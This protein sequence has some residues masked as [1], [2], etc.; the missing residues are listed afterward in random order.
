[1]SKS[2]SIITWKMKS[3]S[4]KNLLQIYQ[5]PVSAIIKKYHLDREITVIVITTDKKGVYTLI[6]AY[7]EII[8]TPSFV[9]QLQT[10]I[11]IFTIM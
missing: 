1:M 6:L 5:E 2:R 10:K 7:F 4:K 9:S 11:H 8:I 3:R